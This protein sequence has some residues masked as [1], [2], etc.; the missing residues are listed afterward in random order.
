MPDEVTMRSSG[1][2]T[3]YSIYEEEHLDLITENK[4]LIKAINELDAELDSH[5][6]DDL[7]YTQV[8]VDTKLEAAA[9]YTHSNIYY[10]KRMVDS[11]DKAINKKIINISKTI[12]EQNIDTAFNDIFGGE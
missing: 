1:I 5:N 9:G 3:Y 7:Y 11:K 4:T 2:N 10:K 12:T 6:H 8:Q